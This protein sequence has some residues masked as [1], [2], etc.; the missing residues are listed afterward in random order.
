[1]GQPKLYKMSEEQVLAA[2]FYHAKYYEMY[3]QVLCGPEITDHFYSHKKQINQKIQARH[4]SDRAN[5]K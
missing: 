2:C 3:A 1:M 5:G 4:V